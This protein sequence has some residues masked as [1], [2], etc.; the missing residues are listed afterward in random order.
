[1]FKK[2]SELPFDQKTVFDYHARRGAIDRLIPPWEHVRIL[3]RNESLYVGNEVLLQQSLG[4]LK[5]EWLARHTAYDPPSAFQDIQVRG[6]FRSW[7]HD[8]LIESIS[9]Q[10]CCLTDSVQYQLPFGLLGQLGA[11]W[12]EKKI[13]SMFEYRHRTTREDL[14]FSAHIKSIA[15]NRKT[16]RI[17]VSGSSGM[18]GRRIC[19]LASVAGVEVVRIVRPGTPNADASIPSHAVTTFANGTFA[20]PDVV[21]QLDAVIHLGGHGI[22]DRRWSDGIKKKILS[23]RVESTAS[24]VKGFKSLQSPPKKFVCAS[25]IGAYGE[26]GETICSDLDADK[27]TSGGDSFLEQVSRQWEAAAR[28]YVGYGDVCIGRLAMAIH[29]LQGALSKMIPLF[30]LGLGG[31]LGSGR[32]YWSWIHVDDA[33]GA[34]LHLALNPTS[35]GIYNLA[36]PEPVTNS[37]FTSE[38]SR[39]LKRWALVPAPAFGLRMMLG[40]MADELLLASIRATADRL[41]QESY[42]FRART[43]SQALDQLLP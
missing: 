26:Q 25:G 34:F 22:A 42:P 8:H 27:L 43:I 12:I 13:S 1:M 2:S 29:P 9:N 21:E 7:K 10:S 11:K 18:I 16:I 14:R 40:Q 38:L 17:G 39:K 5:M 35:S 30:R 19:A 20:D 24:I 36:S 23:S 37:E 32:Q 6:P 4:F 33:A 41:E 15:P 3:R 28:E 31:N